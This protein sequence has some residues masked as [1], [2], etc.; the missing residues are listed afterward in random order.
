MNFPFAVNRL[1]G[2]VFQGQLRQVAP[3]DPRIGT[4]TDYGI[5]FTLQEYMLVFWSVENWDISTSMPGGALLQIDQWWKGVFT[6]IPSSGNF[7]PNNN[8]WNG[9]GFCSCATWPGGYTY[10][11]TISAQPTPTTPYFDA[12]HKYTIALGSKLTAGATA[13]STGFDFSTVYFDGTFYYPKFH[14]SGIVRTTPQPGDVACGNLITIGKSTPTYQASSVYG[15]DITW[16]VNQ[17]W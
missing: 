1:E 17:E 5:G 11:W 7:L 8:E 6:P 15:G 10:P 4:G 2:G 3:G 9:A 12:Q 13:V 14:A 16:T